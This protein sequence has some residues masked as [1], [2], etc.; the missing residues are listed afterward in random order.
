ML[1]P[2]CPGWEGSFV[3]I[4]APRVPD[5][6]FGGMDLCLFP[7]AVMT[8]LPSVALL[9]CRVFSVIVLSTKEISHVG[10]KSRIADI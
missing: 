8:G 4:V 1:K 5:V 2:F 10:I 9:C 3:D 7:A 6:R